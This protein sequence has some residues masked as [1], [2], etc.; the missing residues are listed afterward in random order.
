MHKEM[1][2]HLRD[3]NSSVADVVD[4]FLP[5]IF[6]TPT[7]RYVHNTPSCQGSIQV[8][9]HYCNHNRIAF[10]SIRTIA[11]TYTF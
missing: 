6:H 11:Y 4:K 10:Y 2:L 8:G 7:S 3:R 1:G 5:V 9:L